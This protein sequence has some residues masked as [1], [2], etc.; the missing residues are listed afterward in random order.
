[1]DDH[2]CFLTRLSASCPYNAERSES[3]TAV[4]RGD[5][6]GFS[7]SEPRTKPYRGRDLGLEPKPSSR[8]WHITSSAL[9]IDND[10]RID[11]R[12]WYVNRDLRSEGQ[13]V[14]G[15]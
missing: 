11:G 4:Q 8:A 6:L 1:M 9:D 12:H 7:K 10:R 14:L 5:G 3:S 15:R 2:Q 13:R